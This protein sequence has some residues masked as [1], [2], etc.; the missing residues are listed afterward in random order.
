MKYVDVFI[1]STNDLKRYPK[2]GRWAVERGIPA[3]L[4][5]VTNKGKDGELVP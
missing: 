2:Q 4:Y 1:S 5:M 3:L